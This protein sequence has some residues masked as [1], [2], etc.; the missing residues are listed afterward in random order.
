METKEIIKR[1]QDKVSITAIAKEASLSRQAIIKQL[2]K[3]GVYKGGVT[4]P[5][6]G[7]TVDEEITGGVTRGV[8]RGVTKKE[9][10]DKVDEEAPY[11]WYD[12]GAGLRFPLSK[13][14]KK[15][16]VSGTDIWLPVV[17]DEGELAKHVDYSPLGKR[18][19]PSHPDHPNHAWKKDPKAKHPYETY[20][21]WQ[22]RLV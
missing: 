5:D 8:T 13:D 14:G 20:S 18:F 19:K 22:K 9:P 15:Y 10:A 3:A 11:G 1:Y 7:V 17:R 2:K 21:E 16:Q 6:G 4:D 12:N